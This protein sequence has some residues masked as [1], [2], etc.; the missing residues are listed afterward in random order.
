MVQAAVLARG[1]SASPPRSPPRSPP[2]TPP[3]TPRGSRRVSGEQLTTAGAAE[4]AAAL[5]RGRSASPSRRPPNDALQTPPRTPP[6]SRR[7]SGEQTTTSVAAGPASEV[8]RLEIVR[9]AGAEVPSPPRQVP[10]PPLLLPLLL[11]TH[12]SVPTPFR[13][14]ALVQSP[15]SIVGMH[16]PAL[17]S[18]WCSCKLLINRCSC[19]GCGCDC[20]DVDGHCP[21]AAVRH[22]RCTVQ[23]STW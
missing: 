6:D 22:K 11:L 12:T 17:H 21:R 13:V 23:Q 8:A 9:H 3:R 2:D 4:P 19:A 1:P 10:P 7:T 18:T 14:H 5:P 20:S 15:D 16:Q